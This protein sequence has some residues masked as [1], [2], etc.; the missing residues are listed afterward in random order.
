MDE[1]DNLDKTKKKGLIAK[2]WDK[3]IFPDMIK[4]RKEMKA[5]EKQ[6]KKEAKKEALIES[7][8]ILKEHYKQKEKDK[9]TKGG[10]NFFEKLGKEFAGAGQNS[11]E[12]LNRM[13]GNNK[14]NNKQTN[15][16]GNTNDIVN[17]DKINRML[18]KNVSEKNVSAR[19]EIKS[20]K[21]SDIISDEKIRRMLGK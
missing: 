4:D 3:S 21:G 6:I 9:L 16:F 15:L 8:D 18:G 10:S 20:E 2:L 1:N 12:K 5:L 13:L 11:D 19:T 14:T 17:D 7:K